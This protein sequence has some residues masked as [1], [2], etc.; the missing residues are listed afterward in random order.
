MDNAR[1]INVPG[2][3]CFLL[4]A[5]TQIADSKIALDR[6]REVVKPAFIVA[7]PLQKVLFRYKEREQIKGQYTRSGCIYQL[8][9]QTVHLSPVPIAAACYFRSEV[10]TSTLNGIFKALEVLIQ[11]DF[12]VSLDLKFCK[13][14]FVN[15][16]L[17]TNWRRDTQ[18][19]AQ[20]FLDSRPVIGHNVSKRWKESGLSRA[21]MNYLDRPD[22]PSTQKNLDLNAKLGVLSVDLPSVAASLCVTAHARPS[23][24][25][26][27]MKSTGMFAPN[28]HTQSLK[29]RQ[30]HFGGPQV[31]HLT[32]AGRTGTRKVVNAQA[33][34]DALRNE[35]VEATVHSLV[36]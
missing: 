2:L 20:R 10:V 17:K 33:T 12:D 23:G 14:D 16:T 27:M 13:L 25:G 35:Q 15:R 3:G 4:E 24:G 28:S 21:M 11:K 6:D 9:R 29:D 34:L 18:A 1:G 7:A 31:E 19:N 26:S 5:Q 36:N 22:T 32:Q 8:G 30:S